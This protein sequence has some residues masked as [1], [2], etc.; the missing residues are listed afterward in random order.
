[1]VLP[2]VKDI[3]VCVGTCTNMLYPASY[4]Y[5]SGTLAAMPVTIIRGR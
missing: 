4:N 1:M 5:Y 3:V 2:F